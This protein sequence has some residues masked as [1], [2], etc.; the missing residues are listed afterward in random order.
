MTQAN[1]DRKAK[2]LI[3]KGR[4]EHPYVQDYLL[5]NPKPKEETKSKGKN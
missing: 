3:E 5:R 4:L 1:R 2:A